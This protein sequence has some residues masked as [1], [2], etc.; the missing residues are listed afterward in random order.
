MSIIALFFLGIVLIA[1]ALLAGFGKWKY[2]VNAS[3]SLFIFGIIAGI[4]STAV[5]FNVVEMPKSNV[6]ISLE[7]LSGDAK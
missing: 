7:E 6:K 4:V 5:T 1:A 2:G 3:V